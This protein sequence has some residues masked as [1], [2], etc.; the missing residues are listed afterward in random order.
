[1]NKFKRVLSDE[2]MAVDINDGCTSDLFSLV[3][4]VEQAVLARLA[5]Q[6][7]VMYA[8]T[9]YGEIDWDEA[10]VT[11]SND[12]SLMH[13]TDMRK[14]DFIRHGYAIIPLYAHPMPCVSPT[15]DKTACVSENGES[16]ME[17]ARHQP[18]GCVICYC[19]NQERCLGCG[20]KYCG[21]HDVG[22]TPNPVYV[23][24]IV[25]NN[26]MVAEMYWINPDYPSSDSIIEAFEPI[27]SSVEVNVGDRY[28]VS[29]AIRLPD[30]LVEV[31]ELEENGDVKS[32]RIVEVDHI[33]EPFLD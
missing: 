20:A 22:E 26:K 17:L 3:E 18:C 33:T 7:P 9:Y 6:E 32:Y 25:D 12:G 31:T 5:E 4:R 8:R 2:E 21:T 27:T 14:E 24:H 1:M 10:C 19:E 29:R 13:A 30:M 23:D 16:D 28:E 15:S 11:E